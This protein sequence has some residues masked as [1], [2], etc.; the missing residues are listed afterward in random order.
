MRDAGRSVTAVAAA[1]IVVGIV[2]SLAGFSGGS[3][4]LVHTV[5]ERG[6]AVSNGSFW[7][8]AILVNAPYRGNVSGNA[9][10]SPGFITDGQGFGSSEGM[11]APNGSVGGV[12]F[13]LNLTLFSLMNATTWGPGPPQG[14]SDRWA[15]AAATDWN[16]S[17][18]YSGI[19]GNRGNLSDIGEPHEYNL[20]SGEGG[21]TV[22]FTNGFSMPNMENVSTCGEPAKR[23]F[24]SAP[25][26]I[27][28]VPFE[29]GSLL[30]LVPFVI[31]F[32]QAFHYSFPSG[33]T[34]AVDN[35]STPGG[36][37]GGWAFDYLGP[38]V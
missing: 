36:P 19:L 5:C 2:V 8:P 21:S 18:S 10:I 16:G 3:N 32:V 13:H 34:W 17:Q 11:P 22:Y 15:I 37:G 1:G 9:S 14:C 35:L 24:V 27:V 38:C 23:V 33:G 20:T 12:F 28:D 25:D 4:P 30:T 26:L 29:L 6:G 31:P 7:V